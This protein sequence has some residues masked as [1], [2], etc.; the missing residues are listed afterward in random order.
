MD[1]RFFFRNTA[2]S[3]GLLLASPDLLFAL[4]GEDGKLID[5][6]VVPELSQPELISVPDRVEKRKEFLEQL[7]LWRKEI[8]AKLNY[9]D[10]LYKNPEFKW[11]SSAFNCYF[12]MARAE[13]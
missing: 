10:Q 6:K 7:N 8:K 5:S 13:V 9:N 2:Q 1:R 3:V 11:T 12:L 4:S